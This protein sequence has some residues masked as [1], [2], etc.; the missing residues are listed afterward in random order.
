VEENE[1]ELII[2]KERIFWKA[3]ISCQ[4]SDKE[5]E[6]YYHNLEEEMIGSNFYTNV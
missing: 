1:L 2:E 3:V 5:Q 6:D 4:L